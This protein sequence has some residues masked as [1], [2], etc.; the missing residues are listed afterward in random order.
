MFVLLGLENIFHLTQ[1]RKCELLIDMEDFEGNKS[2]ARY[3]SF[4]IGSESDGYRLH[5]TGFINGG[6]G[7]QTYAKEK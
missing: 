2:Y 4:S 7:E 5:L 1:R 3:S 6:A